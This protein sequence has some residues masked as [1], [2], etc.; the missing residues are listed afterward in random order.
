[1]VV[2]VGSSTRYYENGTSVTCLGIV[3]PLGK[4]D[5]LIYPDGPTPW[6]G[7]GWVWVF[8]TTFNNITVILVLSCS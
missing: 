2:S 8:I 3:C 5:I 6:M 1:M 4:S 7:M